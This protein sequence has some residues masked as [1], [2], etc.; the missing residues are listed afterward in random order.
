[1]RKN[2]FLKTSLL[3]FTIILFTNC[4]KKVD[5]MPD[6]KGSKSELLQKVTAWLNKQTEGANSSFKEEKIK[7]L[8][9]ALDIANMWQESFSSS[10]EMTIIPLNKTFSSSLNIG[11]NPTSYL[12]VVL[13]DQGRIV[14][15][16]L[17]Q[18]VSN[19]HNQEKLPVNM[20]SK[21]FTYSKG[22]PD[23]E[24]TVANVFDNLLYRISF[25]KG[26]LK[27][28]SEKRKRSELHGRGNSC[29][30]WYLITTIYYNNYAETT[31][32]YI[33]RTCSGID[34]ELEGSGGSGAGMDYEYEVGKAPVWV[35]F[36]WPN[37]GGEINSEEV[38]K[39][40]HVS[41][42][43]QGGHFTS[44]YH[45]RDDCNKPGGTWG[46]TASVS[47]SNQSASS[48]VS[49]TWTPSGSPSSLPISNTK[50]WAFSDLF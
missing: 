5:Q 29:T 24:I 38:I 7:P 39:G 10:E 9:Q 2:N 41:S 21:I 47:A 43:P 35:V 45:S 37:A 33:G 16:N 40:R 48:T 25:D 17:T 6:N 32:E 36:A 22:I 19:S 1:M 13:D 44:I 27:S 20:L 50:Y 4:H 14:K 49:G 30:D 31:E 8:L 3:A 11:L 15:G 42:E 12:V 18:F 26:N 46:G 28:V 23:G 34:N